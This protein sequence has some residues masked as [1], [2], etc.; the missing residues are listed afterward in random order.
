VYEA[1]GGYDAMWVLCIALSIAAALVHI[2]IRERG[3][4]APSAA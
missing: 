2:P 1:T 3:A 4:V